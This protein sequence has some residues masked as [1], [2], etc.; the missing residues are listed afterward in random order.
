MKSKRNLPIQTK[1]TNQMNN[2]TDE[3][4]KTKIRLSSRLKPKNATRD[5]VDMLQ[6]SLEKRMDQLVW[7]HSQKKKQL[8]TTKRQLA[9]LDSY[10]AISGEV[11]EAL[12]QLS[13]RL[14]NELL[15]IL[16]KKLTIALQEV[17]QQPLKFLAKAGFKNS[18][19]VV[20]FAIDRDGNTEDVYRGQGGSVQNVLSVGLRM[21]ALATL[22]ADEHRPFL[23]LDE[24]DCW[25]RPELVPQLVR[26]V[27]E[28]SK[29]LGF[30][31]MM[32]SHHDHSLFDQYAD[33]IF[34]FTPDGNSV[35]VHRLNPPGMDSAKAV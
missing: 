4:G 26:I 22:N 32:I 9:E 15:K 10:L 18:S 29:E 27:H 16:E 30:Q 25:L 23:V 31:V 1:L 5:D 19:A 8:K 2:Q 34:R 28:A 33:R 7:Q 13:D 21:F 20:E 3:S 24:Q 11:T 14:F 17:L 6:R 35:N 12:Q